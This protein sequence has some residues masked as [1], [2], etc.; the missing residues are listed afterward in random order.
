MMAALRAEPTGGRRFN[1]NGRGGDLHDHAPWVEHCLEVIRARLGS[2]DV[3]WARGAA[4]AL[5]QA[6][7][8][9]WYYATSNPQMAA[10]GRSTLSRLT[11]AASN[12]TRI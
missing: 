5:E 4:W 2:D 8:L 7:G 10:L 12:L 6:L 9:T 1:G 3:E 11:D